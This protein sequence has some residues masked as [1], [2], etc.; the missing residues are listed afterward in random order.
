M[1]LRR[2]GCLVLISGAVIC[3]PSA[4]TAQ[5]RLIHTNDSGELVS[6]DLVTG[7]YQP[8]ASVGG[9]GYPGAVDQ[10]RSTPAHEP[11]SRVTPTRFPISCRKSW[12]SISMA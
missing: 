4:V 10:T 7:Q 12:P 3:S 5:N 1:E 6:Y 2:L 8:L 11:S 9:V